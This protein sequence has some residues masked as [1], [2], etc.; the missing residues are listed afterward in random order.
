MKAIVL[1]IVRLLKTCGYVD[2]IKTPKF[3]F[4]L[5]FFQDVD[6]LQPLLLEFQNNELLFCYIPGKVKRGKSVIDTLC[7]VPW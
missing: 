2:F 1:V 6:K 3:I 4:Y 7:G 5:T